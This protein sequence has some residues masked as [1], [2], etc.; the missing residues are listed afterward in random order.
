MRT[1]KPT[2][3]KSQKLKGAQG[4]NGQAV[5]EIVARIADAHERLLGTRE[6]LSS[7]IGEVIGAREHGARW[8][9]LARREIRRRRNA[10]RGTIRAEGA[11]QQ[12]KGRARAVSMA[13]PKDGAAPW[14]FSS[15]TIS[16]L[17]PGHPDY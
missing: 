10:W 17:R 3:K 8:R 13:M 5:R 11:R 4:D 12:P 6:P 15:T 1:Y 16:V 7:A 2:S 14:Y 9:Y